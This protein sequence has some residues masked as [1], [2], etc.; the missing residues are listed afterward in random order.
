M[1]NFP[2]NFPYI[3]A[4]CMPYKT[5]REK[6][7]GVCREDTNKPL[8]IT[9]EKIYKY[10]SDTICHCFGRFIVPVFVQ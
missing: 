4:I 7:G 3:K 8:E 6:S 5:G 1:I 2:K 9:F 10:H